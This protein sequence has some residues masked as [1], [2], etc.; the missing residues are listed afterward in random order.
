MSCRRASARAAIALLLHAVALSTALRAQVPPQDPAAGLRVGAQGEVLFEDQLKQLSGRAVRSIQ[1]ARAGGGG[2]PQ[3]LDAATSEPLVRSLLTR[4]G[5]GFEARKVSNDCTTL[6]EERRLVVS[7][8]VLPVDQEVA[9]TFVVEHEVEVYASVEFRG[10]DKLPQ[11][12]VDELLGIDAG[13]QITASEAR[14]MRKVLLARYARDG[15]PFASVT[16]EERDVPAADGAPGAVVVP[17]TRAAR[18]LVFRVDEGLRVTVRNLEFSGNHSFPVEPDLGFLGAGD[19]LARDANIKSDPAWGFINGGYYSR[20]VLDE[21]LDRLRLFYRGRGFLDASVDVADVRYTP[22]R[23]QVDVKIVVDEGPRYTIRSIRIEHVDDKLQPLREPPRYRA[24]EIQQG[25]K[26]S[27]GD[28]YDFVR[29]QRDWLS[30][31]EFYGQRGHPP[32]SFPGMSSVPQACRVVW[33][34]REVYGEGHVVDVTFLV[35]EGQPKRLQDVVIRGNRF[36]R[37]EVIRR[38]VRVKPGE[39]IDMREVNR[40]LRNLEQTRFFLDPDT[41][42]GPRVQLEPAAGAT[43]DPDLLDLGIDVQD[44][45]TGEIRWGVGISTGQGATAQMTFNKRNFDLWDPPSTANPIDAFGEI[46]DNEA[47]HGGGQTLSML[48]AP[49]SRYSQFRISWTEPDIFGEHYDTHELRVTGERLIRRLQDGYTSDTLQGEIGL[50]RYFSDEFSVGL[51]ARH[52]TVD[53]D[54]LAPDATSIAY[55]AEGQNE[56]RGLRLGARYRDYDD[57]RAPTDGFEVSASVESVGGPLGGDVDIV[58]FEH[59]LHWYLPVRENEMGHRTV[60][61]LEHRFGLARAYEAADDVFVT[62]R[63]YMGGA[64]LRGFDYRRAGPSQFGRPYGGEAIYT[65]TAE[66]FFPLVATRLDGE[67][68]DRELLRGV[69]FT[70]IGLLGLA[71]DDPTFRELRGSWGV[72]IRIEVPM[73]ELPIAIDIGWPWAYEETDDRQQLFFSIAR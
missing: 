29:L 10:L 39:R 26:V 48:L 36:T 49:G 22:D 7:A 55:D 37:D 72:G 60:L 52:S 34:P 58:K 11:S 45:P 1:F 12:T 50:S 71:P 43:A 70:D 61:H 62:E 31:Q 17:G 47:F 69:L 33:P 59:T 40:S 56:L 46:L 5:Q 54:D 25:L 38:R 2:A 53:I 18:A 32:V 42:R 63:F 20:E 66:L 15:F 30:I 51:S 27:P 3:L 57:L 23:T 65:A 67:V 9:V 6:W 44:A 19:Y 64:N 14:A 28:H 41:L 73:L 16:L 8:Y 13:R 68:R 24:E 21:D 4:V 35:V